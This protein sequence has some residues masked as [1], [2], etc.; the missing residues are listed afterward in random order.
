M[1]R[2]PHIWSR[3]SAS[4]RMNFCSKYVAPASYLEQKFIRGLA[5]RSSEVTVTLHPRDA[6]SIRVFTDILGI[7]PTVLLP[8]N[9]KTALQRL[10]QHVYQIE[11][12][13]SAESDHTVD[14]LS[15]TDEN[16]ECVEIARAILAAAQSGMLFDR[17]AVLLRNPDLYQPLLQDAFRRAGISAHFTHGTQRPNPGGR[18]LLALLACASEKLSASRFSEY[19]S[20]GQVPAERQSEP[21]WVPPQGELFAHITPSETAQESEDGSEPPV[22]APRYWERLLVDAAVI[23]GYDRWFRRLEGLQKELRKRAGEL[24]V[25]NEPARSR[26]EHDIPRLKSLQEFALPVVRFLDQLPQAATWNEWLDRLEELAR[27]A[28]RQP[29]MVLSV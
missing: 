6:E 23:E 29:E 8:E 12:P 27:I 22:R 16:R 2:P 21:V 4:P 17:M 15:A 13:P 19:L 26:I 5:D 20:L 11:A 10:R 1:L 24:G 9:D 18:A 25:E 3:N 7:T 14:F 28:L